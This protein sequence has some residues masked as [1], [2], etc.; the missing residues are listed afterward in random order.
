MH[1]NPEPRGTHNSVGAYLD[2]AT[3]TLALAVGLGVASS[4]VPA[5][6]RSGWALTACALLLSMSTMI[7]DAL[8]TDGDVQDMDTSS[9]DQTV[10]SD[11]GGYDYPA[12]TGDNPTGNGS[13]TGGAG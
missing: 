8:T 13:E 11:P 3:S 12:D 10:G 5:L 6:R 7:P 1:T 9:V 2:A 4:P